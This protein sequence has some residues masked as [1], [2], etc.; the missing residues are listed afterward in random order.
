LNELIRGFY[1]SGASENPVSA[2]D[3]SIRTTVSADIASRQTRFLIEAGFLSKVGTGF[4]LTT[5]GYEYAQC[6]DF[7]QLETAQGH[8]SRILGEYEVAKKIVQYV[9]V[10]GPLPKKDVI[11]RVGMVTGSKNTKDNRRGFT[12]FIDMLL[13][14]DLIQEDEGQVVRS[15]E[16]KRTTVTPSVKHVKVSKTSPQLEERVHLTVTLNMSPDLSE[17]HLRSLLKVIKEEFGLK[18]ESESENNDKQR[19]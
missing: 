10:A 17:D 2:K 18:R 13:L 19:S 9:R 15:K 1:I 4:V 12:A 6:L 14:A 5:E 7:G 16:H 11:L 8:L 3:A